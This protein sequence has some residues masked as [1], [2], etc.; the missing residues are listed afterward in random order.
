MSSQKQLALII[1]GGPGVS[2][3]CCKEFANAG[4]DVAVAARTPDK[5]VLKWLQSEVPALKRYK[6]D[7][8]VEKDV[9]NLFQSIHNDFGRRAD[10]VIHN[11][12][13]RTGDIFRKKINEA[14]AELVKK[15]LMNSVFSAFLVGKASAK[16]MLDTDSAAINSDFHRGTIIFTNA[17]AAYKGFP[18]S[19]A[20][21]ASC[22]GKRGLAESMAREF[23]PKGIHVAHVPI[24]GAIGWTQRDGTTRK[25]MRAGTAKNENMIDPE[26]VAILYRQLHE[27][28][29]S[30]WTFESVVRPWVEKW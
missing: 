14:D 11:I 15:T 6:C 29:P 9:E 10:V 28:H 13:G 18:L 17:S 5:N 1:G 7:A 3:A 2:S 25:H 23:G 24:D 4:F 26:H 12:D 20:F 27:Q 30:T 21:A 8:G 16:F 22:A 19:G